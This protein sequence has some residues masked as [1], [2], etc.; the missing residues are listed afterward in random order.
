[1]R[2][3]F[4]KVFKNWYNTD[5]ICDKWWNIESMKHWKKIILYITP[6]NIIYFASKKY[7][8]INSYLLFLLEIN[9]EKNNEVLNEDTQSEATNINTKQF[10]NLRKVS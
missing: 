7:V 5:V 4:G 1:M 2:E 10:S 9:T 6:S 8:I 3:P